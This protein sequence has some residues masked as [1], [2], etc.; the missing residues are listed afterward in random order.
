MKVNRAFLCVVLGALILSLAAIPSTAAD[1]LV[2]WCETIKME[3]IAPLAAEWSRKTGVPV[4]VEPAGILET[5]NKVQMAG[6]MGKGPDVFCSLSG[7]LGQLVITGTVAPIQTKFMDLSNFMDVGLNAATFGGKLYGVPYD[8][9]GVAMIYNKAIWPKPPATFDEVIEKSRELRKQ[10]KFGILWPLETFYHS[11]AIMAGYGSYIFAETESWW[12]SDDIG[13]ANEGAVKAVKLLK[14]LRTEGIIPV[15][16]DYQ[17]APAKFS[18]GKAA[19]IIDGSWALPGIKQAGIDYGIAPIP[20]LDNGVYPA[21]FVSLKWWH[22]SSYSKQQ[23]N[24][25]KLIAYLTTKD[26]MY[27]SF[28]AGEGIPPRHDVL[29]MPDVKAMP[30]VSG[31][32]L[33][34]SYG[35]VVPELPEVNPVWVIMDSAIEIALRGDKTVEEALRDAVEIIKQDIAE[36]K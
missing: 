22:V 23:E 30:E 17:V 10:G 28:K 26:A 11:H 16:T 36:L 21:P 6:P 34:A 33:Q 9:S 5:A 8:I 24:A 7:T 18:E 27:K 14:K 19:A 25:A 13:L 2:V 20:K 1:P 3:T 35:I 29:E 15:G 31:F 4:K 12:D 32:G